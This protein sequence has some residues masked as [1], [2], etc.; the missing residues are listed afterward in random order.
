MLLGFE[1]LTRSQV[2]EF[3]ELELFVA[4]LFTYGA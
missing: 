4:R 2:S 1:S 3:R